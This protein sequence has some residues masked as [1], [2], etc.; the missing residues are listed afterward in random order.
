MHSRRALGRSGVVPHL[1]K[2]MRTGDLQQRTEA[3]T[4]LSY[5]ALDAE[6]KLLIGAAGAIP[7]LVELLN[8][9]VGDE[10]DPCDRITQLPAAAALANLAA[11]N[12]RNA[13]RIASAGGLAPLLWLAYHADSLV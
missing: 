1:V 4:V 12:S 7:V 10:A 11:E 13:G 8:L 9:G 5:L 6:N 2:T 3:A